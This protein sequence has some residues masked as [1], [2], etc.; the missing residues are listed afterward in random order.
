MAS[1]AAAKRYAQAAFGL[2]LDRG[3][4]DR[5]LADLTAAERGLGAPQVMAYL[6]NPKVTRANKRRALEGALRDVLDPLVL[7]FIF[8]LIERDRVAALPAIREQFEQLVLEHRGV[9]RARVVTAVPLEE[10][11]RRRITSRLEAMTGKQV[12]LETAVDPEIMGGLVARIGD[13]VIDG[14]TRT[15][16]LALK[17]SLEGAGR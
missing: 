17:A 6:M 9:V 3:A 4:L 10:A 12:E 16:L 7:N 2:A 15:R 8:L 14:S 5:W 1:V 11:D 13:K